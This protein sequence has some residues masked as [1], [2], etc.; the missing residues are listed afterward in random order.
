MPG[1]SWYTVNDRT[2]PKGHGRTLQ[3]DHHPEQGSIQ[4]K[5]VGTLSSNPEAA[6]GTP[7][8]TQGELHTIFKGQ[9]R[10]LVETIDGTNHRGQRLQPTQGW[11]LEHRQLVYG[12]SGEHISQNNQTKEDLH[13]TT[14][15]SRANHKQI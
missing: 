7:S 11:R 12:V 1:D 2:L 3:S 5:I 10:A 9:G 13:T 14:I 8:W 6:V 15:L 4:G